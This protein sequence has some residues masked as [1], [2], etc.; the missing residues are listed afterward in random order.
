MF[1]FVVW[2][3]SYHKLV[4]KPPKTLHV[5]SKG[6][7]VRGVEARDTTVGKPLTPSPE[8]FRRWAGTPGHRDSTP[9]PSPPPPH[10]RHRFQTQ[11]SFSVEGI[12]KF[13]H[14]HF[15]PSFLSFHNSLFSLDDKH[16]FPFLLFER[17]H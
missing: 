15:F 7:A 9:P 5:P 14:Y 12:C 3:F 8:S 17:L 6:S 1:V 16:F 10:R 2:V 4:A 11:A 13:H